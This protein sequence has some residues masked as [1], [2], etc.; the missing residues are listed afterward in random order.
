MT[1]IS[2]Y[3][4]QVNADG[5]VETEVEFVPSTRPIFLLINRP[6]GLSR[7]NNWLG[8]KLLKW[9]ARAFQAEWSFTSSDDSTIQVT[10]DNGLNTDCH[11]QGANEYISSFKLPK[12]R[13]IIVVEGGD[14]LPDFNII[15]KND[16]EKADS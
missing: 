1:R 16:K 15:I 10:W 12:N 3:S 4:V 6:P 8:N 9:A 11:W 2:N 5:Y 13:M 7:L 14:M